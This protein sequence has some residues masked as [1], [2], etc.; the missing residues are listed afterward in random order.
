MHQ[1]SHQ[2]RGAA[3]AALLVGVAAFTFGGGAAT[4]MATDEVPNSATASGVNYDAVKQ[5]QP[6]LTVTWPKGGIPANEPSTVTLSGTNY[7]TST[8]GGATFGGAYTLFGVISLKDSADPGSWAPT[9]RGVSGKNYDYMDGAGTYQLMVNYPGNLT[10]PGMEYMD[11]DGNWTIEEHP[12]PGATFT[13]QNGTEIDC[14]AEGVQCGFM[15]IGAHGQRSGGVEVFTPVLFEGQTTLPGVEPGPGEGGPKPGPGTGGE[16]PG[17]TKPGEGQ[18]YC[19]DVVI[20][21]DADL[22]VTGSPLGSDTKATMSVKPGRY[23]SC[24]GTTTVTL[25]GSG[26]DSTKP[27][28]V[29]LGSLAKH[30]DKTSWRRSLGGLSGP[31]EDFDYGLP[32]LVV[33]HN[34][35]DGDVASAEMT[36]DGDWSLEI[37]IPGSKFDS[38]FQSDINCETDFCGFFSF[39]AHGNLAAANEAYT[40]VFFG[41]QTETDKPSPKPETPGK[42]DKTPAVPGDV[43]P[44]QDGQPVPVANGSPKAQTPGKNGGLGVNGGLAVTGDD[45]TARTALFAGLLLVSGGVLSATLVLARSRARGNQATL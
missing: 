18:D 36:K 8:D 14:L 24:D 16:E 4:A 41:T 17:G 15:T 45:S 10:E 34:S 28:Y 27:I 21:D 35:T 23:L 39:G 20:P 44:K 1:T 33:A 37:E 22:T 29:G 32:Q 12:V 6:K 42:D 11:A 13:A 25:T 40:P 43:P 26:Y 2:K 9:K 30:D 19:S 7:A 38:F 3:A 31:G 5:E